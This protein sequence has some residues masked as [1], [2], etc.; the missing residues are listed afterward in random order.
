[1]ATLNDQD[2]L[3]LLIGGESDRVEFKE[4]MRGGSADSIREAICAF[5]ND[6]PGHDKPG[7]IFVGASDDGAIVDLPITDELLRQ[8][9]DMKTD[10]NIVPPPTMTVEKRV[11]NAKAVAVITV[12][13]TDSPPARCR[14]RILIRTGPRRGAATAQDE[15]ILNEKRRYGDIPFD[16]RPVRRATLDDISLG[17]FEY[18]YLPKAFA[19]EVLAEN[20]RTIQEQLAATKMIAAPDDPTPTVLGLLVM[21]WKPDHFIPGAWVQFLKID[22]NDLTDEIVDDLTVT[23]PVWHVLERLQGKFYGHNR[24]AVDLIQGSIERRTTLFSVPALEQLTHNAIMHRAYE[25]SY[26]PVRVYW[27]NDRIEITNSGGLYGD[28]ALDPFGQSGLT[29]YRNPNLAD[30]MKTLGIVQR[31]GVGLRWARRWMRETGQPE[32][33]FEVIG[34]NVVT[35]TVRPSPRYPR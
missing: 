15:R 35:A 19:P 30:A 6:L 8:L 31:F 1:M 32:P 3:A 14:G 33:E 5:A 27:Y 2:L 25:S 9:A 16:A 7:V 13:P 4:S 21:G 29:G 34:D 20:D 12:Q 18:G 23:G 28:A 11:L 26:S 17:F 10:G 24:V 22:G